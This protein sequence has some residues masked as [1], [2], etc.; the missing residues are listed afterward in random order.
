MTR[1]LVTGAHG[2]VGR[3]VTSA[4][5]ASGHDVHAVA[6]AEPADDGKCTWHRADLLDPGDRRALLAAARP[7]A[8]VH[9]AWCSKPPRYW[10]D[11]ENITW[12]TASLDLVR[13]F[14]QAGG[15]RV[16][17]AGTCAEYDWTQGY[18]S[19]RTTPIAPS[20][21]YSA[22]KAACGTLL[23][24]YG[25]ETGM[26]VAWGRL[27]FLFGPHDSPLRLIPSLA[28]ALG[29]GQPARC[30]AGNH[31]RDF[32]YVQDAASAI[33]ALLDSTVTG[34]VNIASGAPVRVADIARGVAERVGRPDLLTI[35][36][37]PREPAFVA[38]NVNRLQHE[39]GWRRSHDLQTALDET[40]RWWCSAEA[41]KVTA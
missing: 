22:A 27:F 5:L 21:L 9:L 13:T 23:E 29:S 3:H 20:S 11:P 4:L 17:G 30:T 28:T 24:Q 36:D 16:V 18:C 19:E 12:L 1:V 31:V 40:V 26:S 38:G 10:S 37:G 39:V 41:K 32:L 34:P 33:V 7:E 14:H 35:D 15:T 25:R 8:L 2:F 6:S